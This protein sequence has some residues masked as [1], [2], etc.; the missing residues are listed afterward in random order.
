MLHPLNLFNLFMNVIKLSWIELQINV[1]DFRFIKS[2]CK[3]ERMIK[4]T[5]CVIFQYN[6]KKILH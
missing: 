3:I 1:M 2:I 4:H 6:I 5:K